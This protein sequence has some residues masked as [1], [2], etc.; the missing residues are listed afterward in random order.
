MSVA[1]AETILG[2][3][4]HLSCN[5]DNKHAVRKWL[6]ANG[7]SG[8][9][10]ATMSLRDLEFAYNDTTDK[11]LNV[12]RCHAAKAAIEDAPDDV[13][14]LPIAAAPVAAVHNGHGAN[15]GQASIALIRDILLTGYEP[16]ATVDEASVRKIV[17]DALANIVHIT[18]IELTRA[19]GTSHVVEGH[20]HPKFATLLKAMSARMANGFHP[21]I[22]LCGPTGSGKTHAFF[23]AC[24]AMGIDGYSNGAV[25]MDHQLIGYKDANG[26]YHET[27]L[28]KAFGARAGYLFD[29]MDSSDNSPLLCLAQAL[30]NGH[31]EFPDG[32][33]ARHADSVIV[34]ATNTWGHGATSEFVGRNKLDG[35]IRSRFPVRIHWDYDEALELAIAGNEAWT[36]RVQT[37][38]AKA[39]AAGLKVIIDPRMSQAGAALIAQGFTS[40]EAAEMTFLADLNADQRRIV[41]VA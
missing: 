23:A 12:V 40:D 8:A 24:K 38:R 5:A 37:A 2:P 22:L 30:A 29:E 10:A 7:V 15:G 21:N 34:A 32:S 27:P 17:N 16:K 25:S 11:A 36:R 35:A 26:T 33:V 18:K 39:R 1:E 14:E 3:R 13:A 4:G 41:E 9:F 20:V 31:M 19:D 28:R 6:T